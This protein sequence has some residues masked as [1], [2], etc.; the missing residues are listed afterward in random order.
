MLCSNKRSKP[1]TL[2]RKDRQTDRQSDRGRERKRDR[3]TE[4]QRDRETERQ[5]DRETERQR[6][7]ETER[8]RDRET[9]RQRDRET[10]FCS[11]RKSN[12]KSSCLEKSSAEAW[13]TAF[14][15]F[16]FSIID[17]SQNVFV[18]LSKP[19]FT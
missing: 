12:L 10:I 5:R 14:L 2:K 6:D 18:I 11:I 15:F 7:R 4:R 3:E 19:D 13:Q 8:Q 9:E 1:E 16:G 17:F